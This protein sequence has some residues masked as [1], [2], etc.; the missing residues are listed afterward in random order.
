M[1]AIIGRSQSVF[2]WITTSSTRIL[3]KAGIS[4]PG[5]ISNSPISADSGAA[6]P[7]CRSSGMNWRRAPAGG[8]SRRNSGPGVTIRAMP[9]KA[10]SNSARVTPRG[11]VAGSLRK[12]V[13]PRTP[14]TTR[15][16]LKFQCAM[17]G[18]GS[19]SAATGSSRM[20]LASQP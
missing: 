4:K 5:T 10:A 8:A 6:E 11:P 15:K 2:S 13:R 17:K 9:V 20:P 1:M 3:V 12:T 18:T 19:L 7:A 16:W 14:S